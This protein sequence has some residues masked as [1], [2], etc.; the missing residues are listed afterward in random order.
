MSSLTRFPDVALPSGVLT[1]DVF[2]ECT[3]VT[4]IYFSL[5]EKTSG[6]DD[7]EHT[8]S[9]WHSSYYRRSGSVSP[10]RQALGGLPMPLTIS[11]KLFDIV[12][13][14]CPFNVNS[15]SCSIPA[16]RSD[17]QVELLAMLDIDR[18]R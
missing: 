12:R 14:S 16:G 7:R 18:S 5:Y 3:S 10:L 17:H 4:N 8:A 13:S 2:V 6:S 11:A 15:P 1:I 9:R